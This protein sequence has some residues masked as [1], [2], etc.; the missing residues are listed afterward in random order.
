MRLTIPCEG[1]EKIQQLLSTLQNF[2]FNHLKLEIDSNY[3]NQDSKKKLLRELS[4]LQIEF[5]EAQEDEDDA[6]DDDPL[7]TSDFTFNGSTSLIHQRDTITKSIQDKF[8]Y[9][10][11]SLR[12]YKGKLCQIGDQNGIEIKIDS[13]NCKLTFN[14]PENAVNELVKTINTVHYERSNPMLYSQAQCLKSTAFIRSKKDDSI[15]D[16]R[17]IPEEKGEFYQIVVYGN[18]QA[19]V[20][21]LIKAINKVS[22]NI[23]TLLDISSK[24]EYSN[25][26]EQILQYL[27]TT[28]RKKCKNRFEERQIPLPEILMI[29]DKK[30]DRHIFFMFVDCSA[31]TFKQIQAWFD[32]DMASLCILNIKMETDQKLPIQITGTS[33]E[34][35]INT[36]KLKDN[37][38]LL[39]GKEKAFLRSLKDLLSKGSTEKAVTQY[40]L[41]F[42]KLFRSELLSTQ[43]TRKAFPIEEYTEHCNPLFV[44]TFSD[45]SVYVFCLLPRWQDLEKI[46]KIHQNLLQNSSWTSSHKSSPSLTDNEKPKIE[47]T[48]NENTKIFAE[49][50]IE[51]KCDPQKLISVENVSI[52]QSASSNNLPQ[53]NQNSP[54]FNLENISENDW[55]LLEDPDVKYSHIETLL[56]IG[57]PSAD[58]ICTVAFHDS[59]KWKKYTKIREE[60]SHQETREF[61]VF[62]ESKESPSKWIEENADELS[63]EEVSKNLLTSF[64]PKRDLYYQNEEGIY[65]VLVLL[66]LVKNKGQGQ[67][68]GHYPLAVASFK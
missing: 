8:I 16:M 33:E 20:Q 23:L 60:D 26:S 17:V 13:E 36:F 32:K 47:K 48:K 61:T 49:D 3:L 54:V 44:R 29:E 4:D 18:H 10:F 27:K 66:V 38:L 58:E 5:Q 25:E 57:C 65:E 53:R 1:N 62:Y 11:F 59:A 45:R 9:R 34:E 50:L 24:F 68:V 37:S 46:F 42:K 39:L 30:F 12:K 52:N 51:K 22:G 64:N 31:N 41:R 28:C 63:L 14:G 2:E 6:E 21:K 15:L 35:K 67:I 56:R 40:R 43:T 19:Q 7:N 55:A